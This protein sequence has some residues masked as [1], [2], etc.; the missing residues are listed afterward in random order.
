MNLMINGEEIGKSIK[1]KGFSAC[2][3]YPLEE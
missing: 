2:K 3:S 1:Q